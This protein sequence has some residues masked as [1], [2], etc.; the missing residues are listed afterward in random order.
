MGIQALEL[1]LTLA[2]LHPHPTSH[3]IAAKG[4][5]ALSE[6]CPKLRRAG[7]KRVGHER[8]DKS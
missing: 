3:N 6:V 1:P 4:H 5:P 2:N 8:M 7:P